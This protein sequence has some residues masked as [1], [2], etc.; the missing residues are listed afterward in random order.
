MLRMV[1]MGVLIL[2]VILLGLVIFR[3]KL[4]F[5]WLSLFGVHLVLAALGIYVVNFSGLLT[6]VYIPLNPATIGAVTVL[7]LPGVVMLLGLRI[8]LF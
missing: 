7:G 8:I 2:S 3:K 5:G 4:G 1:A 6:Q